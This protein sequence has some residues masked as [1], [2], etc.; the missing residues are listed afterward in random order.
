VYHSHE[1]YK[2]HAIRTAQ[3]ED[4]PLGSRIVAVADAYDALISWRP[5][6]DPWERTSPWTKSPAVS[7]KGLYDPKSRMAYQ[8]HGAVTR[9]YVLLA[10]VRG[11][12]SQISRVATAIEP[13]PFVPDRRSSDPRG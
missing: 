11:K 10:T 9:A 6:R 12:V 8:D 7:A 2:R 4:I 5:Y 3:D 13:L 1:N